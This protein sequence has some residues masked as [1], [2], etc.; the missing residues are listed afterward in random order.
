MR[1]L[2]LFVLGLVISATAACSDANI[3]APDGTNP[4]PPPCEPG[5]MGSG[6]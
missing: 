1:L 4:P 6:C 3:T 5:L 2:R